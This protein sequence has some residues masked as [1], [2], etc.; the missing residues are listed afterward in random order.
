[1][2]PEHNQAKL[3]EQVAAADL[4]IFDNDGTLFRSDLAANPAIQKCFRE[5]MAEHSLDYPEPTDARICDLTGSPGPVFYRAILPPELKDHS[6]EFRARCV[7]AEVDE[8]GL[9]GR[10]F[11]GIEEMLIELRAAGKRMA[12]ASNGGAAYINACAERLDYARHLD[13]IYHFGKDGLTTKA[14]MINSARR[15]FD[16]RSTVMVGDRGSDLEGAEG[17]GV[18]FV[19]CCFGFA[20]ADEIAHTP[21]LVKS[22]AELRAVL[23]PVPPPA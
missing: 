9:S 14:E 12:L 4:L 20:G 18:P 15:R 11:D 17:A 2:S 16:S 22:V 7:A 8:I 19:G 21:I 6:E 1:M 3:L 13:G 10:F 23:L 5:F